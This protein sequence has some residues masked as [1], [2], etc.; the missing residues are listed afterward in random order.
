LNNETLNSD[1]IDIHNHVGVDLLFYLNSHLPYAQS[2]SVLAREAEACGIRTLGVFPMVSHLALGIE[3]MRRGVVDPAGALE[4]VPYEF[5]NSRLVSELAMFPELADRAI[6]VWMVDPGRSYLGQIAALRKLRKT[7]VCRMLKIQGTI[8]QSRVIELLRGGECF[9]DLAEEW[10]VPFIIHSSVRADD[11]WSQVSDLLEIA[12]RRPGVR[13][14]V[15]HSC[16]FDQAGLDR[17][18]ELP[19]AWFDCSAHRIHCMLAAQNDPAVAPS[20]RRFPADYRDTGAVLAKLAEAYPDKLCWGSDSPFYSYV[21]DKIQLI[22]SYPEEVADLMALPE[23]LR[24]RVG[25]LNSL[26]LLTGKK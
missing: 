24:L 26:A 14:C 4:A 2:W 5:E 19:N 18:A 6:P 3:G 15:A 21:D 8:I 9:L 7:A 12:S 17:V 11:K 23:N 25:R 20:N 1:L 16:R 13:F 10:N 22:S